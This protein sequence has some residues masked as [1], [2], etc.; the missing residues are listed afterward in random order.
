MTKRNAENERMKHRYLGYL[1]DAKGRD[2]AS[3]D[4][5]AAALDRFDAFNR[6]RD[7]KA[8]HFE[9]ARAF[10]ANLADARNLRTAKPLSAS[11]IHGMLAALKGFFTWLSL[12]TRYSSRI[13]VSD[14][15]YFSTP[16][17]VSRV[18]TARRYKACPTVNQVRMM[19][20]AIPAATEIN[21]E[22]AR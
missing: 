8:F 21:C 22:T 13:K 17:N 3:I 11:T 4:A 6:Y 18:A 9:Q 10:K 15:E 2:V 19:I 16:D 5:V 1:R 14:V 20:E 12:Q 7:F